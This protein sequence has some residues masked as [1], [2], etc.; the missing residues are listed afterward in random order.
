[1]RAVV[2]L[3]LTLGLAFPAAAQ[4]LEDKPVEFPEKLEI[5]ISTD[6]IAIS[7]DFRGADLTI[8]GAIEGYDPSL[9]AQ[10]KY[11]IVVALEGPKDNNTVRVKERVFGIWINRRSMTFELVPESY[12]L[13]STRDVETIAEPP[14]LNGVGVGIQ[15]I[16]LSPIGYVGDGSTITEFREAFRRLKE[17]GGF[18]QRDPGGVQFISASLFKATVKL[19]ASVPN[20]THVVRAH[21]FRDGVFIAEKALPL[22]VMKTG[23][24]QMISNAAYNNALAYGAFSV[25]L[26]VLTGWLA[27]IVFRK[28]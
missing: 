21:L 7:S 23:I 6:E 3:L 24:E 5:G 19:P 28:D 4:V 12:S 16:R 2:A 10:R 13:S 9:L 1:M 20:G 8:F 11:D 18:Y 26:A 25:L 22:R 17:S 27:S 15:H 14:V